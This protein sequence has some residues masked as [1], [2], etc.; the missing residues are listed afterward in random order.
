MKIG[1]VIHTKTG[2]TYQC[3]VQIQ[4]SLE[5]SGHQVSLLRLKS[6]NDMVSSSDMVQLLNPPDLSGFDGLVIG[7]PVRAF[8]ASAVILAFLGQLPSLKGKKTFCFASQF[9]PFGAWGGKQAIAKMS[10]VCQDRGANLVGH[11]IVNWTSPRRQS[12]ISQLVDQ[13]VQSF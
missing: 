13:C 6:Q 7:A 3:A 2:N 12:Q 8:S 9:F 4:A 1:I 5:K 10:R 11:A